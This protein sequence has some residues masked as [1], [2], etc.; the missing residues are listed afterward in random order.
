MKEAVWG[1][2][3]GKSC[4][5]RTLVYCHQVVFATEPI[6][7]FARLHLLKK[8]RSNDAAAGAAVCEEDAVAGARA[9]ASGRAV[10]RWVGTEHCFISFTDKTVAHLT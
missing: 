5:P 1:K 8:S 10:G 7:R 6:Q 2:A 4:G 3:C 9:A